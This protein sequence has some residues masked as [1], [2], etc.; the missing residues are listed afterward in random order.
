[1]ALHYTTSYL[2]DSRALLQYYKRLA[3]RAMEQ[4]S[5]EQLFLALDEEGNSIGILV[6]HMAGNMRSRWTDFLT[7]DGE[8]PDRDRDAEFADPPRTRAALLASWE[9]GWAR[10]LG[11]LES[12]VDADLER[13]ITIRGERH[14]V[15]QA[16]NRQI[17]H[18]PHHVGQIVLLARHFAGSRWKTLT[19]A[20][21]GSAE[22]T[23]QVQEGELSQR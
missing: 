19:V 23:R 11:T 8:K 3:E 20:R 7:T 4:V 10:V 12:L 14:S 2:E 18:Y 1:M 16:I 6:K 9:D 17:A 13:S 22:F 5:D 21:N 15:M